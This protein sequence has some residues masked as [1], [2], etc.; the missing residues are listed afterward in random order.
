MLLLVPGGMV[1]FS[2]FAAA[3]GLGLPRSRRVPG[4][5]LCALTF[6]TTAGLAGYIVPTAN[7][8]FRQQVF[9]RLIDAETRWARPTHLVTGVPEQNAAELLR[10]IRI[11]S[12]GTGA[13][14]RAL[15]QR[16]AWTLSPVALLLLGAAIRARFSETRPWRLV[17]VASGVL[18]VGI[19]V[20]AGG[21]CTAIQDAL[22]PPYAGGAPSLPWWCGIAVCLIVTLLLTRRSAVDAANLNG[23]LGT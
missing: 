12:D 15:L 16:L 20:A 19:F 14:R 13:A 23:E 11:G 21:A 17:Q 5:T 18:A 1:V 2:A 6:V 3:F 8:V 22:S 7:E 4:L 10:K 9:E